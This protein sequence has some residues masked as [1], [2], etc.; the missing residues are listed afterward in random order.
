[1][2]ALQ[3]SGPT[4]QVSPK[5]L[6]YRSMEGPPDPCSK[7]MWCPFPAVRIV[8]PVTP[9]TDT[10]GKAQTAPQNR[11]SPLLA[12]VSL[13]NKGPSVYARGEKR[14]EKELKESNLLA[15]EH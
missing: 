10:S 13:L 5:P 12:G 7:S 6:F 3:F 8:T 11:P 1:M 9:D 4:M 2:P 14:K 15:L